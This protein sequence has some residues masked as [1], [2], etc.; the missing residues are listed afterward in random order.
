[1]IIQSALLFILT[2]FFVPREIGAEEIHVAVASNFTETIKVIIP[3]FEAKTGDKVIISSGSTGKHYT[4]I[5]NGA[6]F[7]IF[8]SGDE[9]CPKLLEEEGLA[10]MGSRFTYVQGKLVLWSSYEGYVDANGGV[11]ELGDFQHLAMANPK[12]APYGKAAK[13][14]LENLGLWEKI[15]VER[16]VRG[17]NI[18]QTF[19]FVKS[20]SAELGFISFSQIIPDGNYWDIP[21]DLY[22]PILQ[23]AVLL[24]DSQTARAFLDFIKSAETREIIREYGYEVS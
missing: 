15:P 4:M 11:L 14:V 24:K 22:Q 19:Q 7:D 18:S 1:M 10:I 17:E 9:R 8:L 23:Q 6:P 12:L 16:I 2:L 5:K 20:G 13:E 3:K 21:Q